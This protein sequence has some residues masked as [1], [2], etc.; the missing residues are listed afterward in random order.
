M[1]LLYTG[2]KG[3]LG[4]NT[5]P[6]LTQYNITSLGIEATNDIQCNLATHAPTLTQQY[7][8]VLHAAGKAHVI[9]STPQ[10]EQAFY[11]INLQGTINLCSTLT[12]NPPHSFIFIST[13]AIYGVDNGQN[14]TENTTPNPTTPYGI[15][16]LQAEQYLTKWAHENNV[17]LTILRPSLIAGPNAPGNLRSMVNGIKTGRYLTIDDGKAQ[18]SIVLA[19][20]I[21]RVIP[22]LYDINGTF[23]ICNDENPSVKEIGIIIAKQLNAKQPKNIPLWLIRPFA[24]LGNLLG[25]KSPLTTIKLKKLTQSLTF[26][27]QKL[28]QTIPWE[29]LSIQ[30]H[31]KIK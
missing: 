1:K 20:D 7:D 28:K 15:S 14:I 19:E 16:K 21:A 10:E 17:N 13:V 29:P 25:A 27:N 24:W 9:P 22:L 31:Y 12:S 5:I 26:S 23:N 30:T 11:N 18:K 8:T 3:F 4:A 2:A 6:H